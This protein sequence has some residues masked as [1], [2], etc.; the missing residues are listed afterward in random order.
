VPLGIAQ[1]ALATATE[2]LAT[3]LILPDRKLARDEPRVRTAIARAQALIGSA[4]SYVFDVVGA[5][6]VTLAAGDTPTLHQRAALV[7][8]TVHTFRTCLDAVQL[9]YETAGSSAAYRTC[10][11]DR[12]ARDLMTIGQ[13]VLAQVRLLEVVG[14]MWFGVEPDYPWL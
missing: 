13:H 1:D 7:G 14:G 3:K 8:C 11:L 5:F 4:R 12:H 10:P 9:L 2:L 6:W